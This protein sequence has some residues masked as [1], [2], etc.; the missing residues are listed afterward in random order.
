MEIVITQTPIAAILPPLA[1]P[2][3]KSI[4]CPQRNKLFSII[5]TIAGIIAI[6]GFL[7]L[8]SILIK[9]SFIFRSCFL[10]AILYGRKL[11]MLP[12]KHSQKLYEISQ[13]TMTFLVRLNVCEFMVT[14]YSPALSRESISILLLP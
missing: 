13:L 12:P 1:V 5:V 4:S 2:L 6:H 10:M 7:F 11:G 14:M 8:F 9:L 3:G